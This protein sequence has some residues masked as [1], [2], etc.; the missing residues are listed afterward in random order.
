MTLKVRFGHFLMT[1]VNICESKIEKY[2][3]FFAKMKPL[4][5]HVYKTPPLRSHYYTSIPLSVK[6]DWN[7]K[8]GFKN[9]E[10][11]RIPRIKLLSKFVDI[12]QWKISDLYLSIGFCIDKYI[13]GHKCLTYF[14]I[15]Y[16][17][18]L[19]IVYRFM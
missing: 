17:T 5:T 9:P 15:I 19:W 18:H 7:K 13:H 10:L 6:L 3:Y 2:F 1:H 16:H 4:L 12:R 14:V 11:N 8:N